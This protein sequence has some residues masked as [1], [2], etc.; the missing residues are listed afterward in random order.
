MAHEKLR[1]ES[2][3]EAGRQFDRKRRGDPFRK[4]YQTAAWIRIR[5]FILQR[6]PLCKAADLCVKKHGTTLPSTEVDHIIPIRAGGAEYD[7]ANLQ[8]LCKQDHSAKTARE[9]SRE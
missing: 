8:G 3:R 4:T 6:D 7:P 2:K 1:G 5:K 9:I